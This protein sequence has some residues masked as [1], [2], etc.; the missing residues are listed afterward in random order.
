MHILTYMYIIRIY[1]YMYIICIY[2]YMYII[3]HLNVLTKKNKKYMKILFDYCC[4]F[5]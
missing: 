3:D 2:R 1:R 4:A 5:R